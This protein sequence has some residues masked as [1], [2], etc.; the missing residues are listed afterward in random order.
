[1]C[2]ARTTDPACST[3][4]VARSYSV[5]KAA[6]A[7]TAH[8]GDTVTYTITVTNSGQGAYTAAEPA[9]FSDDLSEVLDDATYNDDATGGATYAS[10]TVSWS[11]ALAV[12]AT[13]TITY[14][15][16]VDDPDAG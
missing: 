5:T 15:V 1:M 12:G 3:S 9:G 8:P 10:S 7:A 2:P 14:S 13:A 16:T 4:V 6:S 11:G